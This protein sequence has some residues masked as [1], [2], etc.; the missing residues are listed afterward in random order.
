MHATC[1]IRPEPCY[2]RAAFEKGLKRAGYTLTTSLVPARARDVLVTWNRMKGSAEA[3]CE[4]WEAAGGI[5]LVAENGY[6]QALDK[7]H[8]NYY[9]LSVG[10]HHRGRNAA[11]GTNRFSRLGWTPKPQ[12]TAGREV[13]VLAQRGI[14]S[15]LMASPPQWAEKAAVLLRRQTKLPVRI[16]YHPGVRL[17]PVPLEQDLKDAVA[18][19]IWSSGAGV[20][21]LVEG[22]PVFYAAPHWIA[23]D[24]AL[25]LEQFALPVPPMC[26][27][28]LDAAF[29]RVA[30]GQWHFDEIA[31]GEPFVRLRS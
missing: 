18:C 20:R 8:K 12:R 14:G 4:R 5:V 1:L 22:V 27:A 10:Q 2:R 7:T 6:L 26:A 21:A 16:R 11:D 23:Q 19:V 15:R 30:W 3:T 24:G 29:R 13:L 28:S 25:R 9:A 31:S 17:D